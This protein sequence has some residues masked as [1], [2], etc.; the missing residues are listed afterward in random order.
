MTHYQTPNSVAAEVEAHEGYVSLITNQSSGFENIA[1]HNPGEGVSSN[2]L[3]VSFPVNQANRFLKKDAAAEKLPVCLR[4]LAYNGDLPVLAYSEGDQ[5]YR[6]KPVSDIAT[7]T[8]RKD[9]AE[10]ADTVRVIGLND[11]L[12][13]LLG[14]SKELIFG[15]TVAT[16]DSIIPVQSIEGY[17]RQQ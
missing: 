3:H 12:Q 7:V 9:G 16:P 13:Y 2:H 1:I 4:T 10:R 17:H 15:E 11:T 6:N 14:S 8:Y 5:S